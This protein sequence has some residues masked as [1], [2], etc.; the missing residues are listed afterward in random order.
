[1][2]SSIA[3]IISF[4]PEVIADKILFEVS[5]AK[6]YA[7]KLFIDGEWVIQC[8]DDS[9]PCQYGK[10]VYA[11]PHGNEIWVMLIEKCWAKIY[12]SYQ[13]IDSG[14]PTEGFRAL[15]GAP[16]D[17]VLADTPEEQKKLYKQLKK[18]Y[19]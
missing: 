16:S 19:E 11:K 15:T 12:G 18:A 6:Y 4:Y 17:Y 3:S 1:M 13:N 10:P 2:L 7:V 14:T 9:F 8:T 5:E